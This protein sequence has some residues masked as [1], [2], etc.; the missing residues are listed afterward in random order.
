MRLR[1][2]TGYCV[3][4][5]VLRYSRFMSRIEMWSTVPKKRFGKA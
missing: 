2:S 1:K 4:S 3:I 5:N